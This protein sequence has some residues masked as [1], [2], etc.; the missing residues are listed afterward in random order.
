MIFYYTFKGKIPRLSLLLPY[1][2]TALIAVQEKL[3]PSI[4]GKVVIYS[5]YKI[6]FSIVIYFKIKT[7]APAQILHTVLILFHSNLLSTSRAY[8]HQN[9]SYIFFEYI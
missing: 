2:A 6:R 3:F 8:N 4:G 7:F 9:I 5:K 1:P